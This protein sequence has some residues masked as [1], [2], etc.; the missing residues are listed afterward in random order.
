MYLNGG[1]A[2]RSAC[3]RLNREAVLRR[4]DTTLMK[5]FFEISPHNRQWSVAG[6]AIR[7]PGNC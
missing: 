6:V 2:K 3:P 1:A 4:G 7:I 5:C